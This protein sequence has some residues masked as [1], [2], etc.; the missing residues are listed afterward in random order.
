M[1][2][3][4]DLTEGQTDQ[5]IWNGEKPK[6][7][8]VH[9]MLHVLCIIGYGNLV[10]WNSLYWSEKHGLVCASKVAFSH[11]PRK[12]HQ[13]MLSLAWWWRDNFKCYCVTSIRNK[14]CCG[15]WISTPSC[16]VPKNK[17]WAV[18]MRTL[19]K[20]EAIAVFLP[21]ANHSKWFGLHDHRSMVCTKTVSAKI[22]GRL[23]N[24]NNSVKALFIPEP[25]INAL[26]PDFLY[27][28]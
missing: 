9:F 4:S 7:E 17:S 19:A 27:S 16:H 2:H 26:M 21:N 24:L 5:H 18:R 25:P 10:V 13:T 1:R 3:T 28:F 22:I 12:Y 11:N 15:R 23:R 6:P 20:A 14:T 8:L